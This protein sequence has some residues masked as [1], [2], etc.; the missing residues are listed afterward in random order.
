M[1]FCR[2]CFS[3]PKRGAEKCPPISSTKNPPPPRPPPPPPP[4]KPQRLAATERQLP[5]LTSPP[6]NQPQPACHTLATASHASPTRNDF[7]LF[8]RYQRQLR[9][10]YLRLPSQL[11]TLQKDPP[12][13]YDEDH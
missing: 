2:V 9:N 1:N 6:A 4:C 5:S 8:E 11:R 7:L 13:T 12:R 10:S 3:T